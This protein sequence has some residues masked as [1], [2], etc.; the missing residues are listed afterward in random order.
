MP[1][2]LAALGGPSK[3]ADSCYEACLETARF[4][5][6]VG[7][8]SSNRR[9]SYGDN[10]SRPEALQR[11]LDGAL[12]RAEYSEWVRVWALLPRLARLPGAQ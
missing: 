4:V 9:T 7:S 2:G 6:C 12:A 3:A 10:S 11:T 8:R 5:V 1:E